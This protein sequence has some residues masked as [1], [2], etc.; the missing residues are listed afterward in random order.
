[1]QELINS[2]KLQQI[3]KNQNELNGNS[4]QKLIQKK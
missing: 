1:M 4:Q 2:A 3:H